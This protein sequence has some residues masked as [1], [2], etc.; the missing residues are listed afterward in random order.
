MSDTVPATSA[1]IRFF[2][3][4]GNANAAV[5]VRHVGLLTSDA[6]IWSRQFLG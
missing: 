4:L 3:I 6:G 5:T 1:D 2:L